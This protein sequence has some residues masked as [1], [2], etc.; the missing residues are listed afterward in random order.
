MKKCLWVVP[1]LIFPITDN[2]K[3]ANSSLLTSVRPHFELLDIIIYKEQ[4][5]SDLHLNLYQ[6]N[7][8]PNKIYILNKPNIRSKLKKMIIQ[9]LSFLQYPALPVTTGYF[10]TADSKKQIKQILEKNRYDVLVFDGLHPYAAF[11]ELDHEGIL[12]PVVYRAQNIEQD[13]FVFAANKTS[14]PLKKII[15]E[16]QGRK[17]AQLEK[18]IIEKSKKVWAIANEDLVRLKNMTEKDNISL[19]PYGLKFLK[20]KI[21][22]SNNIH[23]QKVKLLFVGK[24][25]W[26]PNIDGLRWFLHEIWPFVDHDKLE[27]K[28]AGEGDFNWADAFYSFPSLRILGAV[29]DL[30]SLYEETD[31]CIVPIRYGHGE[32]VKVVESISN[33]VPIIS[34]P[35][36]VH[37][38]GLDGEEFICATNSQEWIRVLNSLSPEFS[39]EKV[40][41]AFLKFEKTYSPEMVG[42]RAYHS[43]QT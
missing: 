25:D 43:I 40:R 4:H 12:P 41:A 32:K 13:Y 20:N 35:L 5:E 17:M 21:F 14:N 7:F 37:E 31:Y 29:N 19:V 8:K 22:K 10:S 18:T 15:Y 3:L 42:E 36:G 39:K 1:K 26:S 11:I 24:L 33:G 2:S 28:I 6:E 9:L 30:T 16:W 38:C 34:T 23:P 27:L